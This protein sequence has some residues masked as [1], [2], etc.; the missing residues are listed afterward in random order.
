VLSF[1]FVFHPR[2][3]VFVRQQALSLLLHRH[4]HLSSP[5]SFS[6]S[7]SLKAAPMLRGSH[8]ERCTSYLYVNICI[9][10]PDLREL[11]FM[12]RGIHF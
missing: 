5:S 6:S 9:N 10:P 11:V 7:Y 12:R 1:W 2:E 8:I 3:L 4:L